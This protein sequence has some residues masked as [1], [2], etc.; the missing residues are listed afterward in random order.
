MLT[1]GTTR[2]AAPVS[3]AWRMATRCSMY[4]SSA[5]SAA[6]SR[7]QLSTIRRL[8]SAFASSLVTTKAPRLPVVGRRRPARSLQQ[9]VQHLAPDRHG[10]IPPNRAARAN[11][12]P[13]NGRQTVGLH[14]DRRFAGHRWRNTRRDHFLVRP[15][16]FDGLDYSMPL[17][18]SKL[19]LTLWSLGCRVRYSGAYRFTAETQRLRRDNRDHSEI[20]EKRSASFLSAFSAPPL[21][22]CGEPADA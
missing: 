14:T 2:A 13:Q 21:R 9:C 18:R 15:G 11:Q 22:L 7:R 3:R 17:H 10:L 6:R 5:P 8:S 19:A 12:I 20:H 1:E 16:A 4:A